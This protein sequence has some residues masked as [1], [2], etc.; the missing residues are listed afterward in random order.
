MK[1]MQQYN[2]I[3]LSQYY[4]A[5]EKIYQI[6]KRDQS[7]KSGHLWFRA[8]SYAHYQLLPTLYR[9]KNYKSNS[10]KTYSQINLKE[11]QRYQHFKA[12]VYHSIQS[13]PTYKSEWM[14]IYQHHLGSS[15]LMD[16]SE[17]ART[18][19][20][21]AL[22]SRI[23]TK[24][25]KQ[26][27]YDRYHQTPCIWVLNPYKLNLLSYQYIANEL[28][29]YKYFSKIFGTKVIYK[30]LCN[31]MQNNKDIYFG[32]SQ[33]DIE[34]QGI[35]S[36]C[37]LEDYRNILNTLFENY[38]NSYQFNPFYY[39]ILRM[40]SDAT[41]Y[42]IEDETQTILPPLAILHPYH[43][44]RIRAQRGVF[45]IFPNYILENKAEEYFIK[46]KI[47]IRAM[48]KQTYISD[49]IACIN[50][51]DPSA[52][53]EGLIKNGERRT[54]IYPDIQRYS[55]VIETQKYFY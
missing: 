26:L 11:E 33:E 31:E 34:I 52:V 35:L 36:L 14:E 55:D 50:I 16:W 32:N 43:S 17:S 27:E 39:M 37:V 19:L 2:V 18:A 41:P 45:T 38:V 3:S 12:R 4:E 21:F 22:E 5:V 40:Y 1:I 24:N 25:N 6:M 20:I 54:E 51:L 15:R 30:K 46:R 48:E 13:N 8:H 10:C 49:C 42:I 7:D 44:E 29:K 23:N 9:E 53:A 28:P 47:D